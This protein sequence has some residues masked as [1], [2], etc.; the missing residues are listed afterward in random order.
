MPVPNRTSDLSAI[1]VNTNIPDDSVDCGIRVL[2]WCR[3][4]SCQKYARLRTFVIVLACAGLLQGMCETYF[5]ISAKQ[6]ALDNDWNPL[7]V[8]WLLVSSGIFQAIFALAFAYW[9]HRIHP[10]SWLGGVIILQGLTCIISMLPSIMNFADG[11]RYT[12]TAEEDSICATTWQTGKLLSVENS[13]LLI[14]AMLFV[15]QFAL[16]LGSLAFYTIGITYIDDNSDSIDSPAVIATAFGAKIAGLQTGSML[17]LGVGAI[18]LGW[19]LG[20][21]ILAPLVIV[22]G[23]LLGLF[24]KQLPKTVIHQAAQRIIEESRSRQFGSQ[25]S[26]Y[27]DDTAFGPS[28]KRVFGNKLLMFNILS[29]MFIQ[30]ATINFSLQE[31]NYLQSRFYLPFSEEDG[32]EQE[33]RSR[34]ISFFLKPA[35]AAISMFVGGLVISKMKLS[36][37]KIASINIGMCVK[38]LAIYIAYIFIKCEVGPLAGVTNGKIEQPACSR[39]CICTPTSF[40]PVCPENS[41]V[42]YF[43]PCY[44][45]CTRKTVIN[46]VELFEGCSCG[47]TDNYEMDLT[48]SKRATLGACSG[49]K[50]SSMLWIFQMLSISAGVVYG[51]TTIG[52]III[53]LR[54]VLPQDKGLALAME[55]MLVGLFAYVPVHLAY[56]VVSRAT[57]IYWAPHYTQ[58]LLRETPKHGNILDILSASLIFVGLI[59]D[60]LVFIYIKGLNIYNC[61]VTDHNYTPSLYSAVPQGD[62]THTAAGGSPVTTMTTVSRQAPPPQ[63]NRP[64]PKPEI[65]VFRQPSTLT[66]SSGGGSSIVEPPT[67]GVTY[68]QVVFPP[69]KRKPNDGSAS[70]KRMA[71]RADVPLHHLSTDDVRAQLNNL[72]SFN[73]QVNATATTAM[74]NEQNNNNNN[75]NGP[76]SAVKS[77]TGAIPKRPMETD[78][79]TIRPQSPETD[80]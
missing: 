28:V 13:K 44:A 18:G 26:T 1:A 49:E 50:C 31:E 72:K 16:G 45:G 22:T 34:F 54:S 41:T 19:W 12:D 58:C 8:E 21:V 38:L 29:V 76:V 79:D 68:A 4:P 67:N 3:G 6:A 9:A 23:I 75:S 77:S 36:G 62:P 61:K 25:F 20:W 14:L 24:P 55:V 27:I 10:I 71:V 46:S 37:R 70:P 57:C 48:N 7:I 60:I 17:V 32:L 11:V 64:A 59:F 5:R 69:D 43:A 2:G 30:S 33:W 78:L 73:P 63:P 42:T 40:M 66:N 47:G 74:T 65:T 39:N 52:K 35:A 56:D 51:I 15:L 80:F 53:S